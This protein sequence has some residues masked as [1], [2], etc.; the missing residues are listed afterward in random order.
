MKKLFYSI[1]VV[2][3]VVC[4]TSNAKTSVKQEVDAI[5]SAT[6]KIETS[7]SAT[8]KAKKS[9]TKKS[10]KSSS[11]S[12]S[13]ILSQWQAG[14]QVSLADVKKY[15]IEKCFVAEEISDAIFKRMW[16]KS[17]KEDCTIPRSELRYIKVLHYT[18]DGKIQLG[19]M[20]CNKAIAQDLI[21]IFRK[22]YD[23]KYP[24][25]R[26]VLVDEYDALDE[27]SM[28]ANNSSC[29]NF[30]FIT[31]TTKLSNHSKGRAVDINT[32]YNPY[33][34]VRTDGSTYVEPK[35]GRAYIDRTKDFDY[36]IDRNDLCYKLF[37]EHGFEWGGDWK[38]VKD[39][40]HF[41]KSE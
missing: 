1:I 27:P 34:K 20:V 4:Y 28:E 37:I 39:Y 32:L 10:K 2:A 41:E 11:S 19:E 40:Q 7:S 15:G 12:Q 18:I 36:K 14:K 29:F 21:D 5:T 3:L 17:Y 13:N 35:T 9:T 23:A 31:G 6:Q 25:E 22:L 8:Q 24:I 26:M 38:S 33:V 30:R 16:K